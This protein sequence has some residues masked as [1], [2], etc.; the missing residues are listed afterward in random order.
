MTKRKRGKMHPPTRASLWMFPVGCAVHPR[1]W[2]CR[3]RK[4]RNE[5]N[6]WSSAD[7]SFRKKIGEGRFGK[8]F[9]AAYKPLDGEE[10][11]TPSAELPVGRGVALKRFSKS[12]VLNANRKGVS[13]FDLLRKEVNIH[14]Q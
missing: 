7:F 1:S 10:E 11:D 14:S 6:S 8:V 13:N 2:G 12:K 3:R 4:N 5:C 9:K